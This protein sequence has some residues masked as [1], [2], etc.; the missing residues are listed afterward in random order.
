MGGE[1]NSIST[2][3]LENFRLLKNIYIYIYKKISPGGV[4][5]AGASPPK[6]VPR[7][8]WWLHPRVAAC[9]RLVLPRGD[10]R[11]GLGTWSHS[12]PRAGWV[13]GA[14]N[15]DTGVPP[16][17]CCISLPA[18]FP[19]HHARGRAIRLQEKAANAATCP[20]RWG[21]CQ[22]SAIRPDPRAAWYR[23]R[24]RICQPRGSILPRAQAGTDAGRRWMGEG[25][26]ALRAGAPDRL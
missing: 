1:S 9:H 24:V 13:A 19:R 26:T 15:R 2:L 8:G 7:A 18:P 21:C 6:P 22:R 4:G 3:Q 16:G 17:R 23:R 11:A 20:R 14:A 5:S 10:H 12:G 25:A